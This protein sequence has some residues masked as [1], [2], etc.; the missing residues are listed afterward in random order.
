MD[1]LSID[2]AWHVTPRVHTDA[3]GSFFEAFRAADLPRPLDVAQINCSVSK[4]GVLRGVHFADVPPGQAKYVTCVSGRVMDVV[5]DLR[6]GSPGF[7]RW[8]AVTL[9]DETRGAVLVAEGLGHAFMALSEEATVVYLCSQPYNPGA[10]HGVHPLDP[11]L[12]IAW[13]ADVEPVLSDK[14]AKA[15]SLEEAL[16]TGLLPDF[17][18][19]E[20][21]YATLH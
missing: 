1:R 12:G 4:S 20:E 19:C 5:V 18:A 7:G 17:Q 8:E 9:D 16:A 6:V 15:P 3:R 10:E 21:F 11:D 2:G 14:D 13:P